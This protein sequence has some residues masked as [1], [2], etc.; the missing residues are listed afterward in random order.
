MS[1][2]QRCQCTPTCRMTAADGEPFHLSHD[3]RPERAEERRQML[4]ERGRA[5]AR[6]MTAN[7]QAARASVAVKLSVRTVDG[8]LETLDTLLR[9]LLR[10]KLDA[11]NV[12]KAGAALVKVAREVISASELE[13]ENRDL[14]ALI[15]EKHP[16]LKK[17]LKAVP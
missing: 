5:G 12:A 11:A 2:R 4:A 3:S 13:A 7:R 8:Q 15:A 14:K 10:S 9:N 6:K 16:E 17:M 1:D